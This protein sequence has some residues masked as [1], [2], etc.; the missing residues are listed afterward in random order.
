[1]RIYFYELKRKV[2][3]N[4]CIAVAC[5]FLLLGPSVKQVFA[6]P[7]RIGL[8]PNLN[9]ALVFLADSQGFFKN[10]GIDAVIKEYES[11]PPIVNDLMAGN[12]DIAIGAEFV[13]VLQSFK[14]PD[15]RMPATICVMSNHDLVVR[16]DRGI[17]GPQDLKGKRVAVTRGSLGEFFLYNYLIFNRIPA[18]GVQV[19]YRTPSEMVRAMTDG[20]IDAALSWPPHTTEMART[21]GAKGARWPAQSGQDAYMVLFTKNR[22]EEKHTKRMEQFLL[23]LVEAEGFI[24]KY[25]DRAQA[26]VRERLSADAGSFPEAWSRARFQLQLT[27]D[28]LVLMEREAK[29]AIRNRVV[30][31]KKMPNFL[32]FLYF[33]ALDK[34]KPQAVSV[35]H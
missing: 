6:E 13:F 32:N 15:L 8:V 2:P 30:V 7:L 20:T 34:V 3:T 16:K 26:I 23:A 1:M 5:M 9:C 10:R 18:G 11:G 31:K 25:P 4:V 12:V 14:Y 22:F 21:L 19:L 35:V 24:A 27:Q 28:M 29:W 33:D 17:V